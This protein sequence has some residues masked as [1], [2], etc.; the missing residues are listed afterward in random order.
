MID[1]KAILKR[2]TLAISIGAK[3]LCQL[4]VPQTSLSSPLNKPFI[5]I[6]LVEFEIQASSRKLQH[7]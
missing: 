6:I 5:N 7:F 3:K 1:S 2:T 4:A